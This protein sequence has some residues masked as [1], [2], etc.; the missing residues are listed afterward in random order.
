MANLK[1]LKN[2]ITSVKS[3]QKITKAMQMVAASKLRKAQ[4]RAEEARPYTEKME[5]M[6][7]TLADNIPQENAPGLLVGRK[8]ADG[9]VVNDT[10]LIVVVSAD[11]GLCGGFNSSI[12][13]A[14][15]QR[16][17]QLK[18]DGTKVKLLTVGKKARDLL[19]YT[20]KDSLYEHF[21]TSEIKTISYK[22]ANAVTSRVLELFDAGE[23]DSC[24]VVY[25]KFINAITQKVTFQHLIPMEMP[26]VEAD[27]EADKFEGVYLY[28]PDEE[29]ILE[30]LLPRNIAVQTYHAFLESSASEQGARMSAMDNAT[31]NSGEMIKSLTLQ[32]NRTRQAAITTELTE[33]VAGAESV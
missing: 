29:A 6:L 4:E 7:A 20:C 23:I 19:K 18:Q 13:K 12:A 10:H 8:T 33:I 30:D 25:N 1:D 28:E 27:E 2:R 26:K 3:T 15:T 9:T 32:Y 31:R 5:R 24:T 17:R 21:D 16:V 22:E 14:V 11:R